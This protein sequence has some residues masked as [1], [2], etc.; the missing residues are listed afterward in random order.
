MGYLSASEWQ[1]LLLFVICF[2]EIPITA[3]GQLNFL[4]SVY[5]KHEKKFIEFCNSDYRDADGWL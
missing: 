4:G 3:T 2:H 5:L 1:R